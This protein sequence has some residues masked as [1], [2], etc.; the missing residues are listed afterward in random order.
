MCD[1]ESGST[2]ALY[3]PN[4]R[5]HCVYVI[6]SILLLYVNSNLIIFASTLAENLGHLWSISLIL[7]VKLKQTFL[8]TGFRGL[9][10]NFRRLRNN[11][12]AQI[13]DLGYL[14]ALCKGIRISES[15][16]FA[17]GIWNPILWNPESY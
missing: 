3:D 5:S 10:S 7:Y 2:C 13:L 9:L 12:E 1:K 15:E 17:C 11:A 16:I 8:F 14:F 4:D 6:Q